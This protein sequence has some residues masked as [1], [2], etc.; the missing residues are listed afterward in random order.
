M[1]E[2]SQRRK[3][4]IKIISTLLLTFAVLLAFGWSIY[5]LSCVTWKWITGLN[6][7]LAIA[8]LAACA[9]VLASTLAVVIGRYFEGK[10]EREALHRD[11]KIVMYD[12][13]LTKLFQLFFVAA[14]PSMEPETLVPYLRE[15]HKK[16]ILWSGPKVIKSYGDW[17][18]LLTNRSDSLKSMFK[19]EEFFLVLRK[20][21]GHSNRGI[22][23]G[24]IIRLIMKN[25]D[26][27]MRIFK[28]NPDIKLSELAEIEKRLDAD[29]KQPPR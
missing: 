14:G 21:L 27:L 20:D 29:L 10:R 12:E 2:K 5:A 1:N 25:P 3:S 9:T 26:L 18:Q 19:M 6:T 23:Q 16:L 15:L 8:L 4:V 11:K 7:N 13:L 17:H 24:D 22:R 28:A